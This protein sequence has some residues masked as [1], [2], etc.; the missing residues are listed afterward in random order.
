MRTK[1]LCVILCLLL[2]L[3]MA[4]AEEENVIAPLKETPKEIQKLLDIA[5]NELGYTEE[6]GGTRVLTNG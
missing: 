5:R 3:P 1:A 2:L 4:L 6:K